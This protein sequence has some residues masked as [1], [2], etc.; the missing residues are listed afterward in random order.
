MRTI[1][2]LSKL[3]GRVYIYLANAEVGIRF[4]QQAE[5]EGFTYGDGVRP[6]ERSYSEIMAINHDRTINFV[7]TNGRIA[8]QSGT[9]TIGSEQLIRVDFAKYISGAVDYSF[10]RTNNN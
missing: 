9:N 1:S 4:L 7:G 6:A 8:F 5:A 2:N 10:K 3:N